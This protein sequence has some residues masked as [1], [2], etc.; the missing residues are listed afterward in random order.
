M[1]F[2]TSDTHFGHANI[3]KYCD[4]PFKHA[5][6][7]PNV[8]HMNEALI[9]NWN[10]VVHDGDVV[11]H[12]GDVALGPSDQWD[13]VLSRLNGYKILVIGN[14]DRLFDGAYDAKHIAKWTPAYE[15]WFDEIYDHSVI[16]LTQADD[17]SGYV[18][19]SHF[20]YEADHMD[21][22][23]YLDHRLPDEGRTLIHGHTHENKIISYS[24]AGTLQIHVG[25]DAWDFTPVSEDQ[26][27]ALLEGLS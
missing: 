23:R 15:G 10:S 20:P 2:F 13:R 5:D 26:I 18:N 25:Q 3:I 8:P 1:R 7:S 22:R 17:K 4:R 14:H 9:E 19:L 16:D 21:K 24:E 6:G 11:Y 12:L 27:I